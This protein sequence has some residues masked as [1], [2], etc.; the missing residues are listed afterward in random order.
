VSQ[1]KKTA[2]AALAIVD[3]T[4]AICHSDGLFEQ[5]IRRERPGWVQG[6]LPAGIVQ[7]VLGHSGQYKGRSIHVDAQRVG[8]VF[9]LKA[10]PI[11]PVDRLTRRERQIAERFAQGATH[12][13]IARA[14]GLSPFTVRNYLQGI[15]SKLAVRDK[16]ELASLLAR[17]A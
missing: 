13:D 3:R 16:G 9:L 2:R 11:G 4:G 12:K 8:D 17:N 15:Y 7:S 1:S 14:L 5:A 6:A 10:R